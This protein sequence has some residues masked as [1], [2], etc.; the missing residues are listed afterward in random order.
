MSNNITP[1]G[2]ARGAVALEPA[3]AAPAARVAAAAQATA[4]RPEPKVQAPDKSLVDFDPAESRRE[5]QEAINRLND[6]L[7]SKSRNLSFSFDDAVNRTVIT[8]RNSSTGEVVRQI[9]DDT[10]LR[11]AHNLEDLKG[12]L[13]NERG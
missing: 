6:H 9:P 4:A 1:L 13:L 3:V 7:Q 2:A 11:V 8:V 10:L 12:L 5:L